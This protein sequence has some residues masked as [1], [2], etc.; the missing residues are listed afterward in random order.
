MDIDIKERQQAEQLAQERLDGWNRLA[1]SFGGNQEEC[2]RYML[3]RMKVSMDER[4]DLVRRIL[5][6]TPPGGEDEE[7]DSD[8]ESNRNSNSP[9]P[10]SRA[11]TPP[12]KNGGR[13]MGDAEDNSNQIVIESPLITAMRMRTM[14]C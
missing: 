7:D 8:T 1:N 9:T 2:I 5:A 3:E 11:T 13:N 6:S 4:E 14:T 12:L 10:T